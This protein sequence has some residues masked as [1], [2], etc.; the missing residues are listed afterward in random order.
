MRVDGCAYDLVRARAETYAHPGAL[1][2]VRPG[3]LDEDLR[4]RDFT[5]NAIAVGLDGDAA[6]GRR[7]R[8]RT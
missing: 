3:T 8:S 5:V 1:P 4:R 7:A 6:R 2:D